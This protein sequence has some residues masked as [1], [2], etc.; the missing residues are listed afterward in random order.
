MSNLDQIQRVAG[1]PKIGIA[2]VGNS[3]DELFLGPEVRGP[4]QMT[5]ETF[6]I[7]MAGSSGRRRAF[8]LDPDGN[9][10]KEISPDDGEI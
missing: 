10:I 9:V 1:H 6:G 8:G 7:L 2:R 4:I 3:P 5:P